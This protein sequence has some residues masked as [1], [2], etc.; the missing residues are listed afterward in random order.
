MTE[1][2]ID[3]ES[4]EVSNVIYFQECPL[5][6]KKIQINVQFELLEEDYDV[7]GGVIPHIVL[8][9]EPLHALLCYV[10]RHMT[11]RGKGYIMSI[12]VPRDSRTYQQFIQLWSHSNVKVTD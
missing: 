1:E 2:S 7:N 4:N 9:G 6:N 12:G 3:L 10:D 11:V 8:H 5:C